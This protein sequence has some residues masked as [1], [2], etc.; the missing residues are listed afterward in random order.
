[1]KLEFPTQNQNNSNMAIRNS[2][3]MKKWDIMESVKQAM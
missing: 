2:T 3:E 1:M